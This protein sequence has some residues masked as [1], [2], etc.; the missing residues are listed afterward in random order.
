MTAVPYREVR[1]GM[2]LVDEGG[3]FHLIVDIDDNGPSALQLRLK[4]LAT[5]RL[6]LRRVRADDMA[7]EAALDRREMEYIYEDGDGYVFMDTDSD[8]Q[9][10][11][12]PEWAGDQLLYLK[13]GARAHVVFYEGTPRC[14]EPPTAVELVVTDTDPPAADGARVK[15]ATLE[16][17]LQILVPA[18]IDVGDTVI[19]DTRSDEYRGRARR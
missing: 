2:V 12:S 7:E 14:L 10:T 18:F 3:Q 19:V 17:G 15:P 6:A 16:T 11:L 13:E 9:I 8:D 5:G 4:N 1:K